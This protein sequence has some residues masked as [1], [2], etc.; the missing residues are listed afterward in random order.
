MKALYLSKKPE[1][2]EIAC[3]RPKASEALI[4]IRLAGICNTD[5]ELIKGY[6]GF[7]GVLG[8]EFVGEVVE[9][10]GEFWIGKRVCGEIN[11]GCG[12]CDYCCKGLSRHCP[13]RSVL[14]ILKKNGTFAEYITL[15]VN[16]LHLVPD[17]ISDVQAVFVE[18]LAAAFEILE[19]VH[20]E[21]NHEVAVIGDG[22]LGLLICQV[23]KLTGAH[24]ILIGKHQRKMRL[25]ENQGVET[26]HL[27]ELSGQQFDVVVEASGSAS[28][29]QTAMQNIRPRGTLVL[30][31][32]YHGKLEFNSAPLV[33]DEITVI[34]SR[35]GP[36]PAAIRALDEGLVE[37]ESLVDDIFP[38]AEGLQALQRASEPGVLKVLLNMGDN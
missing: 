6:M 29:F 33:I 5:L 31:S 19:Q 23:L 4:K 20:I 15:P 9:A 22:K 26:V 36:F 37:V 12:K 8:H 21:P 14:G 27:S 10:P 2:K 11:L 35:C 25:A 38:L 3:P 28:G 13:Y 30:K 18:P 17:S 24:V 34:G 16:N 1:L 32:T 7:Q